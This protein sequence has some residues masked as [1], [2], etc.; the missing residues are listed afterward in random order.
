MQKVLSIV[1]ILLV[2]VIVL[3]ATFTSTDPNEIVSPTFL[4]FVNY[5]QNT[6][7]FHLEKLI[8]TYRELIE[9]A[10]PEGTDVENFPD[11]GFP[12]SLNAKDVFNWIY[13]TT[14]KLAVWANSWR[15]A[16]TV[17]IIE[18][19]LIGFFIWELPSYFFQVISYWLSYFFTYPF[20]QPAEQVSPSATEGARGNLLPPNLS[21]RSA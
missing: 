13:D 18:I 1:A 3:S 12:A 17:A 4:G 16:V 8:R 6:P 11:I 10:R 21:F 5:A 2:I 15:D 20:F 9:K 7:K 19:E 14:V